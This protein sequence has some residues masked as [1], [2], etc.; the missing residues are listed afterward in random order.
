MFAPF[1]YL[2]Q[3]VG[4]DGGRRRMGGLHEQVNEN[5]FLSDRCDDRRKSLRIRVRLQCR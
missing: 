1:C 4:S 5:E 2:S 3:W